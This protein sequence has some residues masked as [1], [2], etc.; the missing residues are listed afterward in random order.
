MSSNV[1]IDSE[2]DSQMEMQNNNIKS[3]LRTSE[4]KKNNLQYN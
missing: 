3:K 1:S 4:K 2:D